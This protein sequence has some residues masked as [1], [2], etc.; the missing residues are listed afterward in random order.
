MKNLVLFPLLL[1]IYSQTL[2]QITF[3]KG[4]F[5]DNEGSRTECLIKNKDW[6]NNPNKFTYSSSSKSQEKKIAS[7]DSVKEFGIYDFSRYVRRT[8]Q[9]DT[10]S[11]HLS[12]MSLERAPQFETRTLFLKVLVS[13]QASLLGYRDKN[14][15][16]FF[17]KMEDGELEPLIY[18]PY[19]T[20]QSKFKWNER[21]RQQLYG[22]LKCPDISE[23]VFQK[24]D[25]N[26]RELIALF[27]RYN[28]CVNAEHTNY[29]ARGK[30]DAF[31]LN[32]RV[33]STYSDITFSRDIGTFAPSIQEYN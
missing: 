5:I 3:E 19:K 1:I 17:F 8:V 28:T 18:K 20:R 10:S 24:T 23:T 4:Y 14:L 21:F 33:G 16:R 27:V 25:Y 15:L 13:G 32:L 2:A 22:Q 11:E 12:S 31:D 6:G 29:E 26:Q 9:V 7:L 30:R